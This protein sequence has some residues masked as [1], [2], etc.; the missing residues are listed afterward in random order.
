[1]R[2]LDKGH[3][4]VAVNTYASASLLIN[5]ELVKPGEIKGYRDLINPKWKGK[6][7]IN[8][9]TMAGTGGKKMGVIGAYILGWDFVRELAKNEPIILRD[10][11]LMVEW[12]AKGKYPVLLAPEPEIA[13]E[14]KRAGAP[15][16]L[17]FPVEGDYVTSGTSALGVLN[18]RPHPNAA[19]LFVNWLLSKEGST[20][21]SK[22]VGVPSSRLDVSREGLEHYPILDPNIKYIWSDTE[23][24]G[25]SQPEHF[26]M[27]KEIFGHLMK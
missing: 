21:L 18:R 10:Q 20:I 27:S 9:P 12:I 13:N 11:R 17:I 2:W 6:V 19:K 4:V 26:R 24:F 25:E 14:F 16:A 22:A 8:D 1:M 7:V 5:T 15:L 23:E 3:H